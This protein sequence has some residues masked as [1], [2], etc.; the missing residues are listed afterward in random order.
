MLSVASI[1][2]RA[3]DDRGAVYLPYV[4]DEDTFGKNFT[5]E[6]KAA[7]S[8]YMDTVCPERVTAS[9]NN[10]IF[11]K[12]KTFSAFRATWERGIGA[13]TLDELLKKLK[14]YHN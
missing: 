7:I 11:Y 5:E 9:Y 1:F 13:D 6:E 10:W 4:F 2:M 8:K 3:I 14:D 12:G